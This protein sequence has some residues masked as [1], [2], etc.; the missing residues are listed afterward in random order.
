[1]SDNDS[2]DGGDGNDTL[3][4]TF[5]NF[6]E[7]VTFTNGTGG[8]T[9]NGTTFD[10]FETFISGDGADTYDASLA[11]GDLNI[12]TGADNDTII[13]GSGNDT[14]DGG[15]GADT[16]TGGTGADVFVASGDADVITDFDTTTG[17]DGGASGDNDFVDLTGFYNQTN[18]DAWNAANPGQTYATPLGWLRA[19]QADGTLGEAGNLVIA[20]DNAA[21]AP[22]ELNA[23]NTGVV[24]F[25]QGTLIKTARGEVPVEDLRQNDLVQTMDNGFQPVRWIGK[26]TVRQQELDLH[27]N[28][29]PIRINREVLGSGG[30]DKDLVVSPQHRLLLVSK[31]AERMFGSKEVLISAKK[32]LDVKGVAEIADVTGVTYFHIL[33]ENH[34]IVFAN[35]VPAESLYLGSEAF[36]SLTDEGRAEITKLFPETAQDGFSTGRCRPFAEGRRAKRLAYRLA[37]N[38]KPLAELRW[39]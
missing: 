14:L 2:I 24:C 34:E 3:D 1:L 36:R 10:N 35:S 12:Q 28:L 19:D 7:T 30:S 5:G 21:V 31:V 15:S 9:D 33:F 38:Q 18:L 20:R 37:K 11:T 13:G 26:R 8:N 29:M 16:L 39:N 23:E 17:I 32:L 22:N 4:A 27:P 25:A 6:G